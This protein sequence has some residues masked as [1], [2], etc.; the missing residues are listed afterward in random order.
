VLQFRGG[1]SASNTKRLAKA[2]LDRLPGIT[3][4][5]TAP[6]ISDIW[7]AKS[8]ANG[9]VFVHI[10]GDS[11]PWDGLLYRFECPACRQLEREIVE[12]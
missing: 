6:E 5:S 2:L 8:G 1:G 4:K 12:L 7:F 10:G 3:G 11:A 9:G